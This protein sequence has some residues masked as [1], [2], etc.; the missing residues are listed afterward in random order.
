MVAFD[1]PQLGGSVVVS[2]P[3]SLQEVYEIARRE[4]HLNKALVGMGKRRAAGDDQ[5][6]VIIG[7]VWN[8]AMESELAITGC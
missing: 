6:H 3:K 4:L 8:G 7:A 5:S 2:R 1:D